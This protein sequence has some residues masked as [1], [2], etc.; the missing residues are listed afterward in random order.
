[1]GTNEGAHVA[2]QTLGGV[3]YGQMGGNAALFIA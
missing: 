2:L 3:P 1:M